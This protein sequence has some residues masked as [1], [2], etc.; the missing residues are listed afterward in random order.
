MRCFFFKSLVLAFNYYI[1]QW[2]LI[3]LLKGFLGD[4][5]TLLCPELHIFMLRWTAIDAMF[6]DSSRITLYHGSHP[7]LQNLQ[8][9]C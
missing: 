5:F 8:L 9:F 2:D 7:C 6:L 4:S 1:E 3:L